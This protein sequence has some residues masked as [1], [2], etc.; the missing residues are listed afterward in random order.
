MRIA[1]FTLGPAHESRA[2]RQPLV[3]TLRAPGL[4]RIGANHDLSHGADY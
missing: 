1:R 2:E 4:D 3:A